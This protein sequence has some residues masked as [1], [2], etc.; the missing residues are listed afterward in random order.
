MFQDLLSVCAALIVERGEGL[1]DTE[2][3]QRLREHRSL[4]SAGQ[5][6]VGA[7]YRPS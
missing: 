7:G 5:V 2:R 1:I 6:G 4:A 3:V